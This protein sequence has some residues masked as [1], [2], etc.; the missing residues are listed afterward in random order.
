MFPT[1]E[2]THDPDVYPEPDAFDPWRFYRM[3]EAGDPTKFHF[4]T[5]SND[6]TNFGAGFHACPG[7]FFVAHELK[8]ILVELLMQYDIK[9]ADGIDRPRDV[10]HDFFVIP[11]TDTEL[12]IKR[13]R[14]V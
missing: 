10:Y 2:F 6:S 12:L 4:A 1:Y 8:I 13:K 7:R 9:F 11:N 5:V 14:D 3:R